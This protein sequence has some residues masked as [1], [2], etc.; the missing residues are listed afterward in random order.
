[1]PTNS[2]GLFDGPFTQ[3]MKE[4]DRWPG[5]AGTVATPE[6]L[7]SGTMNTP[8]GSPV[9]ALD[10]DGPVPWKGLSKGR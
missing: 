9:R 8:V 10:G 5:Y 2:D 7:A 3:P 1:M 4:S 6:K